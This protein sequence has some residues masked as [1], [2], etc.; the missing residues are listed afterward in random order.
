MNEAFQ[1]RVNSANSNSDP[2]A[3]QANL[4]QILASDHDS[5][6]WLRAPTCHIHQRLAFIWAASCQLCRGWHPVHFAR[7]FRSRMKPVTRQR[8]QPG[9]LPIAKH[10]LR[11]IEFTG[12]GLGVLHLTCRHCWLK[13]M[14][15]FR[16]FLAFWKELIHS[17]EKSSKSSEIENHEQSVMFEGKKSHVL[18]AHS[19][20]FGP[21][22]RGIQEFHLRPPRSL[23]P[24]CQV[25]PEDAA[26]SHGLPDDQDDWSWWLSGVQTWT[27]LCQLCSSPDHHPES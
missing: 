20:S 27:L 13:G 6:S 16:I 21:L 3:H 18:L 8:L 7:E 12:S 25:L 4:H 2:T 9:G 5:P 22:G 19:F 23:W 11:V 17:D 24:S 14:A 26:R 10:D 1:V 15:Y